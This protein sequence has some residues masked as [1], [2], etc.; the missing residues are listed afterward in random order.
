MKINKCV[1]K[2]VRPD[3]GKSIIIIQKKLE[4]N[5]YPLKNHHT[6]IKSGWIAICIWYESWIKSLKR[7]LLL[8]QTFVSLCNLWDMLKHHSL[9]NANVWKHKM[10]P[11]FSWW[12]LASFLTSCSMLLFVLACKQWRHYTESHV[13]RLPDRG[14]GQHVGCVGRLR[15][16]PGW[17]MLGAAG[18]LLGRRMHRPNTAC[19]CC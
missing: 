17:A 1:E 14:K 12:C 13:D 4:H 6:T 18:R 7:F 9:F 5:F 19:S 16:G 11:T 2:L 10:A 3:V 15:G 8:K